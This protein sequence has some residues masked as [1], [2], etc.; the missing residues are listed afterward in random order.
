VVALAAPIATGCAAALVA[1]V[2]AEAAQGTEAYAAMRAASTA[3][4]RSLTTRTSSRN[5]LASQRCSK[6]GS[7]ALA[8]NRVC[9][10]PQLGEHYRASPGETPQLGEHYRAS[11]GI[12]TRIRI[13]F[14]LKANG[15]KPVRNFLDGHRSGDDTGPNCGT[16]HTI[17]DG[18]SGTFGNN[19]A[20]HL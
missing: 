1:S 9:E 20:T 16:R 17:D 12:R 10:T 18:R 8:A 6:Y 3:P 2:W 14:G 7:V 15:S 4:L 13:G 5:W 19:G 11:P